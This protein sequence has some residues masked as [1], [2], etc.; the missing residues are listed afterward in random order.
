[1]PTTEELRGAVFAPGTTFR[2]KEKV[3]VPR[4]RGG[5][6]L[7]YIS[8]PVP[9]RHCY[10]DPTTPIS[11]NHQE[12]RVVYK[13]GK[14]EPLFKD[15]PP[16]SL[17]KL[18]PAAGPKP[19]AIL[20]RTAHAA[21]AAGGQQQEPP[22]SKSPEEE[23]L[24]DNSGSSPSSSGGSGSGSAGDARDANADGNGDGDDGDAGE[25]FVFRGVHSTPII[26]TPPPVV[27]NGKHAP[28]AADVMTTPAASV[29]MQPPPSVAPAEPTERRLGGQVIE[30]DLMAVSFS[31]NNTFREGELV[32]VPRSAGGFTYGTVQGRCEC[33]CPIGPPAHKH[34]GWRVNV[35]QATPKSNF[36]DIF[37]AHLGKLH[38]AEA[39][40]S[41]PAA[42][43]NGVRGASSA[44]SPRRKDNA[45]QQQQQR[46]TAAAAAP[47]SAAPSHRPHRA[48]NYEF[49]EV[50]DSGAAVAGSSGGS[51]KPAPT[52][53]QPDEYDFHFTGQQQGSTI[54]NGAT[55]YDQVDDDDYFDEYNDD[56]NNAA[57][58]QPAVPTFSGLFGSSAA[59]AA[60]PASRSPVRPPQAQQGQGPAAPRP[61]SSAVSS[62]PLDTGKKGV[63]TVP[64]MPQQP[65]NKKAH[66]HQ[67]YNHYQPR[68]TLSLGQRTFKERGPRVHVEKPEI[69][70]DAPNVAMR[71]ANNKKVSVRGIQLAIQ[72]WQ[73]KGH[74]V[75]AFIPEHYLHRKAPPPD[76]EQTLGEYMPMADNTELLAQL[77]DDGSVVLCPPQD[78]DDSYC[79]EYSKRHGAYIVTNDRYWDH[80]AR[81]PEDQRAGVTRWLREHCISFTFAKNEFLPNPDFAFL[82]AVPQAQGGEK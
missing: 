72:Y 42:P 18:R 63:L 19:V 82:P 48:R 31:P 50:D 2:V 75:I 28:A 47:K 46:Q 29:L 51:R 32:V 1:M 66:H 81:Q 64:H 26:E 79:I 55:K 6:T 4:S 35:D 59:P 54:V 41:T 20:S 38:L 3:A 67:Q 24:D 13:N 34:L 37:S 15:L 77:V 56:G 58:R 70:I 74:Q 16:A 11:A 7:G 22:K 53:N 10:V 45:G 43:A 71:H 9:R 73:K 52:F 40:P 49:A 21:A 14:G 68:R 80:I 36:K 65:T 57:E 78:Y 61:E 30:K 23:G 12:W 39:T 76:K 5:F 60:A 69:V 8:K 25:I 17:G 62:K 33:A 27:E 44:P